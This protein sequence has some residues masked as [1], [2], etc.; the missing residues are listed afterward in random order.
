[1]KALIYNKN[2]IHLGERQMPEI[3]HP[4]DAIVKVTMSSIC[5]SDLHII[6]GF[7]PR[8]N[9]DIVLGH[10]FVGE[11]VKIGEGVKKL[12]AGDRVSA[13]CETFCGE[14]YFCQR[15]FVNNCEK[16]AGNSAAALTVVRRNMY[17]FRTRTTDFTNCRKA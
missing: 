5:T 8:A 14:C 17:G 15:G 2:K 4:Q 16:A 10:E 11:V 6:K 3:K 1:M 12:H 7:V 9:E 13:N